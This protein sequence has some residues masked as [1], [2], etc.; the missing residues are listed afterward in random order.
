MKITGYIENGIRFEKFEINTRK[1]L[2]RNGM[3]ETEDSLGRKIRYE[4]KE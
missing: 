3:W 1:D 2:F 4:V